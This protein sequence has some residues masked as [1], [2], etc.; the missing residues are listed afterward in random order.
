[1]GNSDLASKL[2]QV[3]VDGSGDGASS[4]KSELNE[5]DSASKSNSEHNVADKGE[6]GESEKASKDRKQPKHR[7]VVAVAGHETFV[8]GLKL[9]KMIIKEHFKQ[10]K[11]FVK[12]KP[13]AH[14]NLDSTSVSSSAAV[15]VGNSDGN[16]IR[17]SRCLICV[18]NMNNATILALPRLQKIS[19]ETLPTVG[20]SD[21]LRH[22]SIMDCG[23]IFLV[24]ELSVLHRL[25]ITSMPT[26]GFGTG[27]L[28]LSRSASSNVKVQRANK[29]KKSTV[30]SMFG[31]GKTE[32]DLNKVFSISS[33]SRKEKQDTSSLLGPGDERKPIDTLSEGAKDGINATAKLQGELAGVGNVMN[34]NMRKLE[35]RGEQL[36]NLQEATSKMMLNAMRFEEESR[37]IRKQAEKDAECTIS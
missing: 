19:K 37:R 25:A 34:E 20:M 23:D 4:K 5:R 32:I 10:R 14:A 33:K 35:E 6:E 28:L 9:E 18:D 2:D 15:V 17:T 12:V 3:E 30:F 36:N 27:P 8:V 16:G 21:Y 1:M 13:L 29:P 11:L 26:L 31:G 7:F 22:V 24:T